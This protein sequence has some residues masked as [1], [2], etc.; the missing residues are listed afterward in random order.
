M[1]SSGNDLFVTMNS[2]FEKKIELGSSLECCHNDL[3]VSL[4]SKLEN[5]K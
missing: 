5:L 3:F 1:T 2:K 4:N